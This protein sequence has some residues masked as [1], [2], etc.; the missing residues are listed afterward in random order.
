[1]MDTNYKAWLLSKG[2]TEGSAARYIRGMELFLRD[3]VTAGAL[4]E[5]DGDVDAVTLLSLYDRERQ[6]HKYIK[7]YMKYLCRREALLHLHS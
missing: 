5:Y 6:E 7:K 2:M 3:M 4:G 1:M